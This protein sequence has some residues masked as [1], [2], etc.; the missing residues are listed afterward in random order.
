MVKK[1]LFLFYFIVPISLFSQDIERIKISGKITAPIGE[2]IEGITIY[3][4]SSQSGTVT[5][6]GGVFEIEAAEND[7]LSIT[8][9]QFATFTV[10][11]DNGVIDVQ[12]MGIYL[13]P[14][15]NQLQEVIVRPYDLLGNV[16]ADVGRI[17]TANV[18]PNWNLSYES[19]E[20]EYE[21]TSDKYTSVKGNKAE[22][23]YHNGQEQYGGDLIGLAA[24]LANLI[25]S[26]SKKNK[27][28]IRNVDTTGD[29]LSNGLRQR[30]SNS[31][32]QDVFGIKE[33]QA[34]DF[35]YFAEENG[36]QM[37]YLLAKNE[38]VLLDF[39]FRKR[40]AYK[41]RNEEN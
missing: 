36:M 10:I 3:N 21:F 7:R 31:Y 11:V 34:N 37:D 22:E 6:A 40:D 15:V 30:F 5:D 13:N 26:S 33:D 29:M 32:I 16:V 27:G 28:G 12:K 23:A 39:M 1:I 41:I 8:A 25:F 18:V 4:V 24:G 9:L 19:M 17:K 20:F 35:I 14:V 38:I 2:D